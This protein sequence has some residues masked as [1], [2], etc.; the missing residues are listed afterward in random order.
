MAFFTWSQTVAAGA[1]YQPLTQAN[2]EWK[3]NRAPYDGVVEI[4]H[5]AAAVGMVVTITAGS[6]EIQQESPVGAGGTA[7]VLR[8]R[9]NQEPVTF[10]VKAGDVIGVRIRNPTGGGIAYQGTIELTRKGGG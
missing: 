1:T 5:D 8:G 2:N 4:I 3:Y 7:G 10:T 9:L 6:D